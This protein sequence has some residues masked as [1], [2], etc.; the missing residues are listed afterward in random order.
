MSTQAPDRAGAAAIDVPVVRSC[1]EAPQQEQCRSF[2]QPDA[3]TRAG[4]AALCGAMPALVGCSLWQQ[5]SSGSG[6]W[7]EG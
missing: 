2:Q 4:I 1:Y 5:C 6:G 3:E 7:A